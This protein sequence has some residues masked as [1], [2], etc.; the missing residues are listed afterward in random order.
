M[1]FR[2]EK[3]AQET[4]LK[5]SLYLFDADTKAQSVLVSG[6]PAGLS[7]LGASADGKWLYVMTDRTLAP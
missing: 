1:L 5:Q 6:L 2:S 3:A 4:D 7:I